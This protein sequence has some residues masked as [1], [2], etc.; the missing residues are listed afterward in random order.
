MNSKPGESLSVAGFT[1]PSQISMNH[2]LCSSFATSQLSQYFRT[3]LM[4]TH[5]PTHTHVCM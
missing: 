2:R 5:T 1:K 3:M 4:D